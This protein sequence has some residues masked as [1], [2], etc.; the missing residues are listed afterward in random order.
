LV[1]V[2]WNVQGQPDGFDERRSVAQLCAIGNRELTFALPADSRGPLRI[3]PGTYKGKYVI[4]SVEI[5][6]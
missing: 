3:D 5:R 6:E 2:F 1:Q 4:E